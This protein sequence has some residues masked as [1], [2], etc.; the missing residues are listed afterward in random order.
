MRTSYTVPWHLS[1]AEQHTSFTHRGP[2][3]ASA[4]HDSDV[5]CSS[6]TSAIEQKQ[7]LKKWQPA[8]GGNAVHCL[9]TY[10]SDYALSLVSACNHASAAPNTDD[11]SAVAPKH[12]R[13]PLA[14][15]SH[16]TSPATSSR[17]ARTDCK[18]PSEASSSSKGIELQCAISHADQEEPSQQPQQ[19]SMPRSPE[20]GQSPSASPYGNSHQYGVSGNSF[21][22]GQHSVALLTREAA[23]TS[24]QG[25]L[26]RLSKALGKYPHPFQAVEP[27]ALP[28]MT[29]DLVRVRSCL[30]SHGSA[31]G[32]GE[33]RDSTEMFSSDSSTLFPQPRQQE[34]GCRP[35]TATCGPCVVHD[36]EV[37][38]ALRV[39]RPQE[40][41]F[42]A[43][44]YAIKCSDNTLKAF[45]H[46]GHLDLELAKAS[47]L[48]DKNRPCTWG[49]APFEWDQ[50]CI[51][52]LRI[53]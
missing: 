8:Q 51:D 47:Y 16:P 30:L 40:C 44:C 9:P 4:W 23:S 18:A 3:P 13:G 49:G 45:H 25:K 6:E 5:P 7:V 42:S 36:K 52:L 27:R 2:G 34:S 15:C 35:S 10:I 14:N 39:R 37:V 41:R 28:Y 46:Q 12:R 31:G 22:P 43:A 24:A 17:H 38:G 53:F 29:A 50:V 26:G 20:S 32:M 11:N 1:L 48:L 19:H 33:D 21:L